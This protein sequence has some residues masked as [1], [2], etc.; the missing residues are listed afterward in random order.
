MYEFHIG[1]LVDFG[2]VCR[3]VWFATSNIGSPG[4]I[5]GSVYGVRMKVRVVGLYENICL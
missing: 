4:S 5:D 1:A 2:R 3:V